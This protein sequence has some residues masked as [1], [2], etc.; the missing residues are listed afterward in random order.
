[1]KSY[2]LGILVA[3]G[4][5]AIYVTGNAAEIPVAFLWFRTTVHQGLWEGG[6]FSAGALL[7]WLFSVCAS[8]EAYCAVRKK[9]KELAARIAELSDEKKSLLKALENIGAVPRIAADYPS[10]PPTA[11]ILPACEATGKEEQK[12]CDNLPQ[13]PIKKFLSSIFKKDAA[14]EPT[15]PSV[16]EQNMMAGGGEPA[17]ETAP[18]S[19]EDAKVSGENTEKESLTV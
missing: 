5:T 19:P 10:E 12:L 8:I 14:H 1:M 9:T 18:A 11:E 15:Q 13:S 16:S 7:M 6:L 4:L 17:G 2:L 3:A